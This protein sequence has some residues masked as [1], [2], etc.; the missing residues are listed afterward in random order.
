MQHTLCNLRCVTCVVL[1]AL[2]LSYLTYV[3]YFTLCNLRRAIFAVQLALCNSRYLNYGIWA[4]R[5]NLRYVNY[6]A[7]LRYLFLNEYIFARR[8]YKNNIDIWFY[9]FAK[10]ALWSTQS[11]DGAVSRKM[12]KARSTVGNFI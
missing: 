3:M 10:W 4:A 6:L 9:K 1:L 7:K 8:I 5:C 11:N 2:W 12:Q